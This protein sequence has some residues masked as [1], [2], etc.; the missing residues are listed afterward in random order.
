MSKNIAII[1]KADST[2]GTGHLMRVKQ[3]INN[4]NKDYSFYLFASSFNDNLRALCQEFCQIN[5]YPY[6]DVDNC[7]VVVKKQ[8][9]FAYYKQLADEILRIK[10]V[11]CIIDH[12]SLDLSFE[13]FLYDK[14]RI[15]IIDDLFNR[16]HQCHMLIDSN[17]ESVEQN[18]NILVPDTCKLLLGTKY[19][20][21][22]KQ[23]LKCRKNH[24]FN[25]KILIC[26]G[27][28][29]PAHACT[30]LVNTI[31][32]DQ[33]LLKYE[34]LCISGIAN[35]DH[36]KIEKLIDKKDNFKLIKYTK[37]LPYLMSDYSMAFG[38]YGV[39]FSERMCLGIPSVCTVIADNQKGADYILKK[40]N[41]GYDLKLS[42]LTDSNKVKRAILNIQE[43]YQKYIANGQK[44]YDGQGLDRIAQNI[45]Q[46]IKTRL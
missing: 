3:I 28:S 45:E 36:E 15:L 13:S 7:P 25:G 31:V 4:L 22:N 10:P 21:I 35:E 6:P 41:L 34:Y 11:L 19:A 20:P 18:Y 24:S 46:L 37:E 38:A 12:Y 43:N 33:D 1:L 44:L 9:I 2:I 32:H 39:M 8:K 26:Y 27:G 17:I 23:F 29:D 5:L 14:S 30:E 16:P 40:Y 42:E